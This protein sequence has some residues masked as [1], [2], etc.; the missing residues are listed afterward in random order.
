MKRFRVG[1]V[2]KALRPVYH[3]TL[4]SR[5]RKKRRRITE[6]N[7]AELV[8]LKSERRFASAKH[9]RGILLA[10]QNNVDPLN[11]GSLRILPKNEAVPRRA[12][13]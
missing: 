8:T 7:M 5:V 1:L 9:Q 3:S 2:I 4:G 10:F 12:R 6:E 13:V 11:P